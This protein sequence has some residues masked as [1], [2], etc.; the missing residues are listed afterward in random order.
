MSVAGGSAPSPYVTAIGGG[1]GLSATLRALRHYAGRITAVVSG[2][3]DGGASGGAPRATGPPAPGDLRRCLVSLADP[4]SLWALAFEHRFAGGELDGHALGNLVIAGLAE[5][6]GDFGSA[7]LEAA[8]L[9]GVQGRV[10]PATAGPVALKGE[11]DGTDVVGQ[12][13]LAESPRPIGVVSIVPAD[14]PADAEAE[15]AVRE[16]DQVV[17]GPGSLFTSVLAACVV[18]GIR[19]ALALRRA[20]TTYVANLRPQ[21]PETAG[22]GPAGLLRA[23]LGHG[24]VVHDVLVDSATGPAER[25][26][27]ARA[28]DAGGV[29]VHFVPLARADRA[30]HDP[31]A[32]GE[33]LAALAP[34]PPGP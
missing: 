7:L 23:V 12:A 8:R 6:T 20:G 31:V 25:R 15:T 28:A 16:A 21:L 24:V 4:E 1:H 13:R 30:A 2:A 22:M 11:V 3:D 5:V 9:L 14:A 19:D 10:L 27:L 17:L 29:G 18:P 32:L 33:A 34:W 26:A